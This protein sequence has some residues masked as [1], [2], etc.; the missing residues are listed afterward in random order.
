MKKSIYVYVGRN[1]DTKKVFVEKKF[2]D[3]DSAKTK[4]LL[5]IYS[6]MLAFANA[7]KYT[8][9]DVSREPLDNK[10]VIVDRETAM[11]VDRL[12]QGKKKR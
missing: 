1:D 11:E 4:Q 2:L 12:Q 9:V 5:D 8:I 6:G 7:A 10:T 3:I